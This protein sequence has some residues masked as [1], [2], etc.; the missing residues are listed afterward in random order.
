MPFW[1][2]VSLPVTSMPADIFATVSMCDYVP[3][4]SVS[5]AA[6]APMPSRAV[7]RVHL[8]V[9]CASNGV[10]VHPSNVACA[11]QAG[12]ATGQFSV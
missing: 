4:L 5:A 12:S 6:A 10:F 8:D 2:T 1:L 9:A 11:M 7:Q 3:E